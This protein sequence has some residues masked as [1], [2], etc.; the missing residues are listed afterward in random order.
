[1]TDSSN[2]PTIAIVNASS[3]Y[4][5]VT[6]S[7]QPYA[8]ALRRMGFASQWYQC[9]DR[10]R[11]PYLP[12]GG[13]VVPGL[14]APIESVEMG[15]NRL[16]CFPHRL[17]RLTEQ[18]V[19]ITDPTLCFVASK[20]SRRVALVHDLLP[21]SRYA[22]RWD[23]R[24][25]FHVIIPKLRQMALVI[26][27]TDLLRDELVRWGVSSN[28]I[29][30]VPYTHGL[31]FHPEH[32]V[33]S[34]DRITRTG[35]ARL[36]YIATDRP[37][38]NLDFVFRLARALDRRG[39][40]PRFTITLLSRL[41]PETARRIAALRLTNLRV[42]PEVPRV[43]ALYDASDVLIYPSLHEGFGRPL[44]EAMAYGL[45]VL[46]N[47]IRPITD[48]LGSA[49]IFLD[50]DSVDAWVTALHSLTASRSLAELSHRSL[51]RGAEFLPDRFQISVCEAFHGLL[52]EVTH[53]PE[54]PP[55]P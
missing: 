5:G 40:G 55:N 9:V 45:P 11:E 12:E 2:Q 34:V 24:L 33:Q 32:P 36:L 48:I 21:L 38:K 20:H 53:Q 35:E 22:D 29:R 10:G 16:W 52:D 13:T 44:I 8:D 37:S 43:G 25:M 50:A 49:G 27:T 4:S 18:V 51:E 42:I 17:R 19:V 39:D 47:R 41:R 15:F 7:A 14:G 46:A 3:R 28:I 31:G 30:V 54:G 23:S 1:M 26:V 6:L